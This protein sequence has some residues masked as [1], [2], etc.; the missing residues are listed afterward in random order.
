MLYW[1]SYS[2]FHF[3][4]PDVA[5]KQRTRSLP[6]RRSRLLKSRLLVPAAATKSITKTRP[7]ATAGPEYPLLIRVRHRILGP[8]AGNFSNRSD[9]RHSLSRFTPIH[10]GQSSAKV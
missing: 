8:L 10:C 5:S 2:T 9:S 7:F 4:L 6:D 3:S 1:H